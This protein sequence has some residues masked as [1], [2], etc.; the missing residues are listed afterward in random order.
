[1]LELLAGR[2]WV[3]RDAGDCE[4]KEG[5]MRGEVLT[6]GRLTKLFARARLEESHRHA[7]IPGTCEKRN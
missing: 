7:H 4:G 2:V 3:L 1:M 5:G 6:A